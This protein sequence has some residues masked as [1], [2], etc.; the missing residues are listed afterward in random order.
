MLNAPQIEFRLLFD[1]IGDTCTISGLPKILLYE[2]KIKM[3]FQNAIS[4]TR[5][6]ISLKRN[7]IFHEMHYIAKHQ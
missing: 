2:R 7:F 4:T 6:N 1:R 3:N 5:I